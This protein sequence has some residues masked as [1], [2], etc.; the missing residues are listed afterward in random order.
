MTQHYL[1]SYLPNIY[2]QDL[3]KTKPKSPNL[4]ESIDVVGEFSAGLEVFHNAHGVLPLQYVPLMQVEDGQRK[5]KQH[6]RPLQ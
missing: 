1:T 5:P 6:L 3:I 4:H 2:W